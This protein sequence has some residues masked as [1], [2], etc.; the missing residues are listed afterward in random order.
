MRGG[1]PW[2]R[3]GLHRLVAM[4]CSAVAVDAVL[5][6]VVLQIRGVGYEISWL[7]LRIEWSTNPD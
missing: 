4:H 2:R 7:R 3:A 1:I 5:S 6:S